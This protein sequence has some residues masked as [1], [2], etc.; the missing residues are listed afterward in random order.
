L[1]YEADE[2]ARWDWRPS[3]AYGGKSEGDNGQRSKNRRKSESPNGFSGTATITLALKVPDLS[4]RHTL[5]VAIN[6]YRSKKQ[7]T[8]HDDKS[9]AF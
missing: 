9:A 3:A 2:R 8:Y 5:F 7:R 6:E 4:A 1:G